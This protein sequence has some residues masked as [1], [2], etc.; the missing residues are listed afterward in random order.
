MPDKPEK[1]SKVEQAKRESNHL[2]GTVA[3]TL[4]GDAKCF[5]GDE[6]NLVKFHGAYQ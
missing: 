1:E 3:A 5:S 2:R 4:A 6:A